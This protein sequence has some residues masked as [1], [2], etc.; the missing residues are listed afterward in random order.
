MFVSIKSLPL[1]WEISNKVDPAL[2]EHRKPDFK[3]WEW[4]GGGGGGGGDCAC[5]CVRLQENN[6]GKGFRNAV[7][8]KEGICVISGSFGRTYEGGT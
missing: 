4:R 2:L 1:I 8:I 3:R 6:E 7:L 5:R